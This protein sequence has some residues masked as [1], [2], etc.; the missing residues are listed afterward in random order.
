MLVKVT[1]SLEV[2][3]VLNVSKGDIEQAPNVVFFR[4]K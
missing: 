3:F 2:R 4:L 1:L